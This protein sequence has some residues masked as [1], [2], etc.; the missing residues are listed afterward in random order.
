MG[1]G[2][3]GWGLDDSQPWSSL[4][5]TA[6]RLFWCRRRSRRC[7]RPHRHDAPQPSPRYITIWV[8]GLIMSVIYPIGVPLLLLSQLRRIKRQLDPPN[9]KEKEAIVYRAAN[10]GLRAETLATF[11]MPY[12]PRFWW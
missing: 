11:A 3:V 5:T 7:R 8:Y 2:G 12:R 4:P 1:W 9:L 6:V 10:K